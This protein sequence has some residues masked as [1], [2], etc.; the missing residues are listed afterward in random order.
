MTTSVQ[1]RQEHNHRGRD[2]HTHT[3]EDHR[4]YTYA[5]LAR[6]IRRL[7][8]KIHRANIDADTRQM[9]DSALEQLE[10]RVWLISF[11][12]PPAAGWSKIRTY[13]RTAVR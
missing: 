6:D 11:H 5:L 13:T 3:A 2:A 4:K 12:D 8:A 9:I 10:S 7:T 1:K